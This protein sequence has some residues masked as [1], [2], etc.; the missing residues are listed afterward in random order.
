MKRPFRIGTTSFIYPDHI[1]PNVKKIGRY[2]DE[3]E[4]LIF[5]S[6]PYTVLPDRTEITELSRLSE[7]LN[8]TYNIHLPTD[9]SL[10]HQTASARQ[11]A[12]D[13]IARVVDLCR[14]LA[15]STHTL[16]LEM[17]EA[18][19]PDNTTAWQ[20]R[21]QDGLERLV[22][23]VPDTKIFSV[24]TLD[25][26]PDC[27]VPLLAAFELTVCL[28]IGHHFRYGYDLN[29]SAALFQGR[30]AV[31]HLHGVTVQEHEV[32]DHAGLDCLAPEQLDQVMALLR[33]YQGTVSLEVFNRWNLDRS[34]AVLA[35]MFD[36]IPVRLPG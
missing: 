35:G 31:M 4:L 8:V 33:A 26:P 22:R 25:Y 13:T 27:L 19:I 21:A 17:G 28:D 34:L 3:I 1:L 14:P 6:E 9:V 23:Q 11:H 30:M 15:P 36:D 24:E 12:A 16:H 10:T 18:V 29:H 20:A 2:F 5:E 7:T 32:R